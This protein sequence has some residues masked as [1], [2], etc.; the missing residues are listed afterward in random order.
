MVLCHDGSI[1][2]RVRTTR[3]DLSVQSKFV[4]ADVEYDA[5]RRQCMYVWIRSGYLST[6]I[7][8]ITV[9]TR[10]GRVVRWAVYACCRRLYP[11]RSVRSS[12]TQIGRSGVPFACAAGG[13]YAFVRR[14]SCCA[15][16]CAAVLY[17]S[18]SKIEPLITIISQLG[19]RWEGLRSRTKRRD[20]GLRR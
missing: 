1:W 20:A 11:G 13:A 14:R 9:S 8:A 4:M 7:C 2:R 10:D 6:V 12:C 15:A 17:R 16:L 3:C 19:E 5:T 18:N